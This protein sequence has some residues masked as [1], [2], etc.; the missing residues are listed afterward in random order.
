MYVQAYFLYQ[1]QNLKNLGIWE[2]CHVNNEAMSDIYWDIQWKCE[3]G[4]GFVFQ[5]ILKE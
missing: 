3:Q 1:P 5:M 2:N 4:M